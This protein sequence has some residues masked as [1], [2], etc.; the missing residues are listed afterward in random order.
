VNTGY[1]DGHA[2]WNQCA[3]TAAPWP[4]FVTNLWKWQVDND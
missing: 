3:A 4:E 1:C 2:K